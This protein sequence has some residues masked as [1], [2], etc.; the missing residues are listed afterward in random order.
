MIQLTVSN[1]SFLPHCGCTVS[2]EIP[3]G[4]ALVLVGENGI[5]KS[6]L[7]K[8][9]YAQ[10][11]ISQRVV[12]EQL[13]TEYFF[14]RKLK[15]LK[16]IFL[17]AKLSQLDLEA[18]H[19]LWSAF[20]LEKKENRLISQLSGGESQALKLCLSLCK[21]AEIYFLDEPSQYL[22]QQRKE[23]LKNFLSTMLSKG[24]RVLLVEHNQD[25]LAKG[26]RVQQLLI[27]QDVLIQG[28]EWTIS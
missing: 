21:Q 20:G 6:T 14:D 2:L 4:S 24:T 1:P 13:G 16:S 25:W 17:S 28:D 3:S 26:W 5:G 11:E 22:D 27:K 18:F 8:E 23:I 12:V 9:L 19:F 7:L 15:V 10:F